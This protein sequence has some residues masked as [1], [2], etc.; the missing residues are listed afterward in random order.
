ME[1]SYP[2][3]VESFEDSSLTLVM[4]NDEGFIKLLEIKEGISKIEN[5]QV[6]TKAITDIQIPPR[7]HFG[8]IE[9]GFALIEDYSI[10]VMN[11]KSRVV[12]GHFR[13]TIM[14]CDSSLSLTLH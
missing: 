13:P 12:V 3:D 8:G 6:D 9:V 4:G 2:Q 11:L 10:Y 7:S 14:M 1:F 5:F